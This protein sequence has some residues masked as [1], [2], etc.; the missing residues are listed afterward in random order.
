[1]NNEPSKN[2]ENAGAQ[3]EAARARYRDLTETPVKKLIPR[4][5]VPTIISMLVTAIY[6]AADTFFV[7]RI[8]TAAT[9]AVGLA[10]SV[11][12]V[13]QAF[14]FFC[15]QGSGNFMS[16]RLGAG[17][18]REAE[19]MAATG[20]ALS[21]II[22]LLLMALIIVS[23]PKLAVFLGASPSTETYTVQ[24]LRIIAIGAPFMT[25]QFVLNNQLRYQG[26]AVYAMAGLLCGAVLNIGLDPLLI[27][28][29][30]MEVSGAALATITGQIISFFVLLAGTKKGGN[31]RLQ[32]KNV[33]LNGYYL[34]EIVN[35][36][37]PAL[38]RQGLASVATILLNRAAGVYGDAAIAGMSVTTRVIMFV[39]SALIGFGQGY[40]PVCAFNYGAGKKERVREG[41]FFCVRYGTLFLLGMSVLCLIFAPSII[42][43][44]R[45][46]PAVIEV[47]KAA[48]RWQAAALPLQATVV[49]SNMMLQAT[50]KG[51]KASV[52]ASARSGLF[53]I[54][55]ILVLPPLLGLA[56]VEMTQACADVLAFVLA[57][58]LAASELKKMK[59]DLQ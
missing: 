5:A 6:N 23:A 34:L 57:V 59:P 18:K 27:F 1:M 30:R 9:A 4:L 40:Q 46:D 43:F 28:V 52:T 47:S 7:G 39:Y 49:I 42:G 3:E 54:P 35:G 41:Y 36:G 29:F 21:F 50:G 2:R 26:S 22:G 20:F 25:G 12:A 48:L 19:E 45:D 24:Y 51:V 53:F 33:R 58:P 32:A 56:G 8:S 55:L 11:M 15:G 17:K 16:R 10:F 31:I 13:I 38:F 14:G 44:F 37:I